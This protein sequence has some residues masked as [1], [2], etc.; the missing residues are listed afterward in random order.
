MVERDF[1]QE[2]GENSCMLCISVTLSH[3]VEP[4]G[5]VVL[6]CLRLWQPWGQCLK[7][8]TCPCV[9][10]RPSVITRMHLPVSQSSDKA[11]L[12]RCVTAELLGSCSCWHRWSGSAALP[13]SISLSLFLDR[14]HTVLQAELQKHTSKHQ[15]NLCDPRGSVWPL[16]N[17]ASIS[18]ALCMSCD[19]PS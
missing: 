4:Q 19:F 1:F 12:H 2:P 10:A 7:E 3:I 15:P 9:L 14:A 5:P 17:N 18:L 8:D 6:G 16:R 11:V 13:A